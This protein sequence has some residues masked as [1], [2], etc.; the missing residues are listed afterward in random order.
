[1]NRV[2]A[3]RR[4]GIIRGVCRPSTRLLVTL[5]VL[6]V[7][8]RLAWALWVHPAEDYVFK[9]MRGYVVH[10]RHLV[11]HGLQPYRSMV[12]QAWGTYALLALPLALFGVD[13]LWAAALLWALLGA[14]AV[15]IAY[16]LAC[17]VGA[18]RRVAAA[19]GV[20]ALLWYPNLASSGLFLSETPLLCFLLAATWRLVVLLQDGRGALG[21]GI[22]CA[23]CFAL[24]PEVA[25]FFALAVGL[26]LLVRREHPAARARHV[27]IV[28]APVVIVLL[29]SLW[30]F[31][32]HTGRWGSIAESARANLTPARCHHPWV[33]AYESA[34]EFE[35]KPGL[36]AGRV[37]GV[38]SFFERLRRGDADGRLALRPVFGTRPVRLEVAGPE[39]PIPIRIGQDGISIQFVGHRADPTIHAA[40][41][42][43]CVERTGLPG[44]LRIS[45][46]N[47]AGLWFF[48]SQWPDNTQ[49]SRPFLPWS[50]A[51]VTIFQWFVWLPSLIGTAVALRGARYNPGLALCAL[52]LV[53]MMIT[54]AIWFGEIRLRTPYDPLALLLA[55]V[56]YARIFSL[57]RGSRPPGRPNQEE[58]R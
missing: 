2:S 43:A 16:L 42:R 8:T 15:P 54:A 1:M 25:L 41:Q 52:P 40:L 11:E 3:R 48:G 18:D 19:V 58:P 26:W 44:Q 4:C 12:F 32:N 23:I 30:W 33:Q 22:L 28:A 37:Y 10:A 31:H 47:L 5:A 20:G 29:L 35:R 56:A 36:D 45:A 57:L 38:T 49:E 39:G 51:F 21:C 24:R 53:A 14:A 46:A 50:N 27:G 7:A 55:A 17:R 9:D 34:A 6:A 13:A